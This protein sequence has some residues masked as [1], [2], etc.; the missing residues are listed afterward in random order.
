MN[1]PS[2]KMMTILYLG[3]VAGY[4]LSFIMFGEKEVGYW[5]GKEFWGKGIASQALMEFLQIIDERPLYAHAAKDNA[6]SIRVLQKCGFAITGE[7]IGFARA[8]GTE[9]EEYIFTLP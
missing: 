5:L 4:V 7:E 1:D 6:G 8:R 3:N 2:I 9:I